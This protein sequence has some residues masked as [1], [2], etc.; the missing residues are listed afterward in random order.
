MADK[1][2]PDTTD[3]SEQVVK[4]LSTTNKYTGQQRKKLDTINETLQENTLGTSDIVAS[5]NEASRIELEN[6]KLKEKKRC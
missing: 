2:V 5:V 4:K 3:F 1:I 6:D